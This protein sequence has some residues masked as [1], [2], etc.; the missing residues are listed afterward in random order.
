MF[1][2]ALRIRSMTDW[3]CLVPS[4]FIRSR[5]TNTFMSLD[6]NRSSWPLAAFATSLPGEFAAVLERIG[7]LGF[8]H[9][10]VVAEIDRP[11]EQRE[12]LADSGLLVSCA[13]VGRQLPPG[14][15][16]D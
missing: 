7:T 4:S 5:G 3:V 1:R 2:F 14:H 16:L 6:T 15:A 13:A 11:A 9:V 8:T 10:D 12:A